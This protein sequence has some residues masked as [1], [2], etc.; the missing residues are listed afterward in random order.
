MR[1]LPTLR[2]KFRSLFFIPEAH[3]EEP[4]K[5]TVEVY[6]IAAILPKTMAVLRKS[7]TTTP[8]NALWEPASTWEQF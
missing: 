8:G 2:S 3:R 5:S 6:K 7:E 4:R 1:L